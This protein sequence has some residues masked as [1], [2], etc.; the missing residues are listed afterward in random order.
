MT[1]KK[2]DVTS[3]VKDNKQ[4]LLFVLVTPFPFDHNETNLITFYTLVDGPAISYITNIL[5]YNQKASSDS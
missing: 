5:I 1:V 2:E 4:C 3:F